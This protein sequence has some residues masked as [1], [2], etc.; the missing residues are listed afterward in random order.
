MLQDP[1]ILERCSHCGTIIKSINLYEAQ[2]NYFNRNKVLDKDE[3]E[4]NR[5][6]KAIIKYLNKR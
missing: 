1:I 6:R 3:V 4:K 2:T 5:I